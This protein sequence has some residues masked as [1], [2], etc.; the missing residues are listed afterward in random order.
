MADFTKYSYRLS[1]PSH[2]LRLL[3]GEAL[4][5]DVLSALGDGAVSNRHEP[6]GNTTSTCGFVPAVC[7]DDPLVSEQIP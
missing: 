2:E 7:R 3:I 1:N 6:V 5:A 4:R